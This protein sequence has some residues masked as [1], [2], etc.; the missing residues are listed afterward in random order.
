MD[1]G[2]TFSFCEK[3]TESREKYGAGWELGVSESI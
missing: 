1:Q 2:V 3:C